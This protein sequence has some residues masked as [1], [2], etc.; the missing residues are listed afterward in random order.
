MSAMCQQFINY[1]SLSMAIF[2]DVTCPEKIVPPSQILEVPSPLVHLLQ[3]WPV[4]A[5][6]NKRGPNC[7]LIQVEPREKKN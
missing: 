2:S 3:G 5:C 7:F 4:A 1:E 6:L